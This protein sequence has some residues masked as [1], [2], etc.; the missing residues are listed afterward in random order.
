MWI[1]RTSIN[2]PVFASMV[3]FA[4]VVLG[5]F[6]YRLLPVEQMPEVN[7]PEVYIYV[8]YPGAS[9]EAIE[10]DVI[11]PIENVINSVDG[12]KDIFATAREGSANIQVQF[13]L[14][15]DIATATQEVR[16]KVA[17]V[18]PWMPREVRDPQITRAST[19]GSQQPV[20]NLTVYSNTR[21]LREVS[22]LVDQQIVKR[23]ENAHGV[24]HIWTGGSV[25][26]QIQIFLRPD[27]MQGYRVGVDQVIAAI[28]AANQDL[29]AG[30]ITHGAS[31][32]LVRV[33]GKIKDPRGF[34]RIIVA[35]QGG[36]P[37][38]LHQVADIVDGEAEETSIARTDGRPSVSV[39]VYRM[40][41]ANVVETGKAIEEAVKELRERLPEDVQIATVWS[42]S[43]W[44]EA[45]LDRVKST[46]ME[47]AALTVLIVFLFLHSWRSTVITALTLPI[48]VIATFIALHFFG[49][50][51]N[52]MTLMALSLCIGLLIDD[53]IVVR[54]NIVRHA[55]MGKDHRTAALEGTEEIGLAVMA[56]TFAILAVFVPVAFMS[57]AIGR[58][59]LQFGITVAVAVA[60]S[61]FVSFT[62]DPM[63]SSVW[64]DPK[65][66]RFRRMP[67]LGRLMER[68]EAGIEAAHRLYDR[69]LRWALSGRRYG[70][71]GLAHLARHKA[72]DRE[73]QLPRWASLSPRSLLLLIAAGSFFG[74]F[75][76]VPKIGVE[77]V[78][79]SDDGVIFL[80]L[81]TPIGSSLEYTDAKVRD[82]EDMLHQVD[83]VQTI[84][85]T[86][87][88]DEGRN[89]AQLLVR[90]S[91]IAESGRRPQKEI[92]QE[93]RERVNRMAGLTAKI[94]W[95]PVFISVLGPDNAKLTELSQ[96]LMRRLAAV[97]GIVD[98][99]SSEKGATPTIAVR[100]NNEM[101]SDL[102]LTTARIGNAL[103][104]LI[105][106]DQITT[107]LGPDGQD[108]D[109]IVR[110]PKQQRE[111]T[112]DLG[113]LYISSARVDANGNS[114]LVPLRQVAD[115]V[116]TT[117][118]EQIKRLNMQRRISV[119]AN[120]E[121]R[122]TGDVGADAEKIAK[123]MELPLG[124][125]I[126]VGG[127]Q[128]DMSELSS[129][130]LAALS[131]AVMFIYFVLASQFGSF[132]QPI[133]I[134][135]SL[136]LSLIGVLLALLI[137]GTTLNIFSIIGFIMLMGL[138]TK[139]A[140]LLVDFTNHALR[141]GKSLH[142]AI[143]EAGQ[144][145]L[146]PILMTT[147]AMI[148]GMLPMS[149]GAGTGGELLAPMGR[150]V[151]GGVITSTLLTLLVVPVLYTYIYG[152]TGRLK[153][154]R[155]K[156]AVVEAETSPI[157]FTDV[158][159]ETRKPTEPL[160]ITRVPG[161]PESN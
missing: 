24:G 114:M 111:I 8:P 31:D 74:S 110:L 50:T 71:P 134:M 108:Y 67:W 95:Q 34:E 47:G 10:S 21:S 53:A 151:I 102:G 161:P 86:V 103:R 39:Y 69:L 160:V 154:R 136:P 146:R 48:S 12:V 106:G 7:A 135:A 22:T 109:V 126:E 6:S 147:M 132:F 73:A 127:E 27:A 41:Q 137:T 104:P 159:P 78:P 44:I 120:A 54:E 2:Q 122:P 94:G 129:A 144:V 87:G 61:L 115:L 100:I 107:W 88:T 152:F 98:L 133:A 45:S 9:P 11:K 60:V 70:I 139:N 37:V 42:N 59:F 80:R 141:Q 112:A 150:A 83:G 93:I 17:Q 125:R 130:A 40:Q 116:H 51:L 35:N 43:E 158:R 28:Q 30:I 153:A 155:Q 63:L 72:A 99:E 96:E 149:I 79:Q 128:Q 58:F 123:A 64:P 138:V 16:D 156:A 92:E 148:F 18:K 52:F 81:N 145:R 90:L 14:D 49:F 76:L 157:V 66:G 97:P 91:D 32:R 124:Y 55:S 65:E 33:E 82:V 75:L 131:L 5:L 119:Y 118:P 20:V 38:Y 85:T 68:V 140:I 36:A 121:G 4:L 142:E 46:I 15:V 101:A 23:L 57:G 1:T 26:R 113:D 143:W 105:A 77:F 56:T 25:E 29:P 13:E 3:M 84:V 89:Y 19:D 62:L 117:T